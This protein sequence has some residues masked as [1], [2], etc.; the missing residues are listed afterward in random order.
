VE[1]NDGIEEKGPSRRLVTAQILVVVAGIV[2]LTLADNLGASTT[3]PLIALAA[4]VVIRQLV[5]SRRGPG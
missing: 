1:D 2:A 3:A 5:R 4:F